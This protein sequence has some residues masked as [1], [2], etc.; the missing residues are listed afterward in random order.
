MREDCFSRHRARGGQREREGSFKLLIPDFPSF[1]R[2]DVLFFS[3]TENDSKCLSV[4]YSLG[5]GEMRAE[6]S[7]V[8][9]RDEAR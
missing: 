8:S 1:I 7:H 9:V 5:G 2:F 4:V 6:A 3:H